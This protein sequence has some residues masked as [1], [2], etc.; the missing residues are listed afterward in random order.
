MT[1]KSRKIVRMENL[2]QKLKRENDQLELALLEGYIK[3]T[4]S[5]IHIS[6]RIKVILD[7]LTSDE[8]TLWFNNANLTED[9]K[10]TILDMINVLPEPDVF[11]EPPL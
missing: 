11:S 1:R 10:R 3:I 8:T 7:E 5:Y 9:Q 2:L 6:R 4:R